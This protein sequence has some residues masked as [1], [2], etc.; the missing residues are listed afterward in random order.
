MGAEWD[1]M[2]SSQFG[3][4]GQE[5]ENDLK[6]KKN[7]KILPRIAEGKALQEFV[8]QWAKECYRVLKPGGYLLSFGGTRTYHRMA[9]AIE[10]VGFEIRDMISWMYGC[11]SEDTEILTERG[12]E[13]YHKTIDKHLVLCYN[14]VTE[15]FVFDKPLR[16][17]VYENQ[18][19]AYNIK[20]DFTDQIVSRNHRVIVE[21]FG[22]LSFKYA[23][24]V[25]Q[26]QEASVPFLESLSDLPETI[27]NIYEG[28]SV[29]KQELLRMQREGDKRSEK[30]DTHRQ[31]NSMVKNKLCL[32]WK[33]K[34]SKRE[35]N[36]K[37]QKN[38]LFLF[39]SS[40]SK[41]KTFTSLLC[42]WQGKEKPKEGIEVR[43]KSGMER[44]CNI[45]Q[46]AWKL[47]RSK[48]YTVSERVFV[49]GSE[50]RLCYGTQNNYGSEIWQTSFENRDCPSYRPQSF[51][52]RRIKSDVFSDQQRPQTIRRT[53]ATITPIEYKGKVWCI[54]TRVGAFVAR[55][56]GQIFIT[57]NS[58]F[59]KSQNIS[60]MMDKKVGAERKVVGTDQSREK[61][62]KNQKGEYETGSGWSAGNR[63]SD[64]TEPASD[65]AKQWDGWG[66]A[67]KPACEPICMARKPLSEDT[68]ADN[69]LKHGTGGINIDASRISHNEE[70]KTTKRQQRK[71][72]WNLNN[73]GFDSTKNITASAAPEGRFPS[74]VILQCTCEK[75]ID[76][77][78]LT[79]K[80]AEE[81]KGGI[82]KPSEGKPAGPTY[83][84]GVRIHTD[85]DCPCYKLDHQSGIL[86]S[87][88]MSPDI[89]KR[90][91]TNG[92]YQS[93]HGIYGTYNNQY[94]METFGDMGGASRFFKQ[95]QWSL[96]MEDLCGNIFE[97]KK[98]V[99]ILNGVIQ[100]AERYT[101][102]VE[103][104]LC[105][106]STMENFQ[107]DMK[108]IIL[109]LI[110]Q[111]TELK[112]CNVYPEKNINTC[113]QDCEKTIKLLM[114]LNIENAKNVKN[115]KPLIIFVKELWEL[116]EDI[117][118]TVLK[119]LSENG[120]KTIEENTTN[121][122]KSIIENTGKETRFFY[123]AKASND[124][125]WFYCKVC[126]KAFHGDYSDE[127]MHGDKGET[128][129]YTKNRKCRKCG[130]QEVSGSPCKC[131]QPDWEVIERPI[132]DCQIWHPT[133]K[134]EDLMIYLIRLVTPPNEIVLDPF[135]GTGTTAMA[136]EKLGFKYITVDKDPIYC[137]IAQARL[138]KY[139]EQ[140][141]LF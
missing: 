99:G 140:L 46:N 125:K 101:E 19:T 106:N 30:R 80:P 104:F 91:I 100:E 88:Y 17:F 56:N 16:S 11:L 127:H 112:T 43:K 23:E 78:S 72:G 73:C 39:L 69:V 12:W 139:N 136:C 8:E 9:C 121:T 24:E 76:G 67:L 25:A 6:V 51:P 114:E 75:T 130:H 44:W 92:E 122:C 77:K 105:G 107:K 61:R 103:Q 84:G 7:F 14:I 54:E 128:I 134:P 79:S 53:K 131:E 1:T 49:N 50:R 66:T 129:S 132:T 94:L 27:P 18:Y 3:I 82:F 29:K 36:K 119:N 70:V 87:G 62:L 2:D 35:T 15:E 120:E 98:V 10:D 97:R 40:K 81:S 109:T 52:Q 115:I 48:I 32:L 74:N 20:S 57:G 89:H 4:A 38:I 83:E 110:K 102:N 65:Q 96:N 124:E 126:N 111:M 47:C 42:K 95:I 138:D 135:C 22:K 26:E 141:R 123:Q 41:Y 5:G 21:Q 28:A 116:T 37:E 33:T 34:R 58:G 64:I 13:H 90:N 59:P 113:T 71:A 117:V 63:S 85:P 86:K 68:V 133:Q 45:F 93:P 31:T 118:K 137:V 108:S 60:L 55:R